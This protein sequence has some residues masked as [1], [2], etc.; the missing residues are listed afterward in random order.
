MN[1][2]FRIRKLLILLA[3]VSS[4]VEVVFFFS[5]EALL[6]SSM[7]IISIIFFNATFIKKKIFLRYPLSSLS[8]LF[9]AI[10]YVVLPF[11]ATALEF[12]P[13]FFNLRTPIWTYFNATMF[14]FFIVLVHGL[15]RGLSRERNFLRYLFERLGGFTTL[16]I[17]QYYSLIFISLTYYIVSVV[18][19]GGYS[20]EGEVANM[21]SWLF[22][23]P[24]PPPPPRP[25]YKL[26]LFIVIISSS[27]GV[28][29]NMRTA[30]LLVPT[31]VLFCLVIYIIYFD[32]KFGKVQRR[33]FFLTVIITLLV[34]PIFSR[35]STA[36]LIVR[37]SR[38][39]I[40]SMEMLSIVSNM[41][42]NKSA[43]ADY[44][45]ENKNE[46][47]YVKSSDYSEKYLN[48]DALQRF[49]SIKFLDETLFHAERI[50]Y[51]NPNMIKD[52]EYYFLSIFPEVITVP[53]VYKTHQERRDAQIHMSLTDTM[54]GISTGY[55]FGSAYIGSYQ[56]I[57]LGLFGYSYILVL[58][59]L[60][61][62][63]FFIFD[64][65]ALVSKE[66]VVSFSL[67]SIANITTIVMFFQPHHV[68]AYEVNQLT[69][70]YWE[71]LIFYLLA[72][73]IIRKIKFLR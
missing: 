71:Q 36:M 72:M 50:G 12:K 5:T 61:V 34:F 1:I 27:V 32:Y 30:V 66:G 22:A 43:I 48:N 67:Y 21:P 54:V 35:I 9:Y 6:M 47:E 38:T 2:F 14:L 40:S 39:G 51:S 23:V 20:D 49:C 70:S 55:D 10:C 42:D 28:L 73:Y 11:L 57:G 41:M 15:Y 33:Y 63:F 46:E 13:V 65:L 7:M 16:N 52:L 58:I 29:T 60:F 45:L 8:I 59:P 3:I 18:V 53:T 69:R 4:I 25:H 37:Q 62:I 56:G 17:K 44:L 31:T 26:L 64:S 24:P 68:Y 19:F